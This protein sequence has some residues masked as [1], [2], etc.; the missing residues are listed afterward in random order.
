MGLLRADHSSSSLVA[1]DWLVHGTQNTVHQ[2]KR[3]QTPQFSERKKNARGWQDDSAVKEALGCSKDSRQHTR[4]SYETHFSVLLPPFAACQPVPPSHLDLYSL[5]INN[6][7]KTYTGLIFQEQILCG[8][9]RIKS[10][11]SQWPTQFKSQYLI[12][13]HLWGLTFSSFHS[14][15]L[16]LL[17]TTQNSASRLLPLIPLLQA[18]A[19]GSFLE[20]PWHEAVP[21]HCTLFP[22]EY[23]TS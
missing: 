6:N 4:S 23:I 9:F 1:Q 8:L 20:A 12:P 21:N 2:Q 3:G 10:R 18:S 13:G 15:H 17:H 19:L 14:V 5:Q 11:V 7:L 16:A 22:S